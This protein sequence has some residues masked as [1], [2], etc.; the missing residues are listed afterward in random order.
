MERPFKI[1][2]PPQGRTVDS[3]VLIADDDDKTP[4]QASFANRV[5]ASDRQSFT[6]DRTENFFEHESQDFRKSV[7]WFDDR[8][9]AGS[10]SESTRKKTPSTT[11]RKER[12]H[13]F[14]AFRNKCKFA[15]CFLCFIGHWRAFVVIGGGGGSSSS[16]GNPTIQAPE[17]KGGQAT[18]Q[19]QQ[20]QPKSG[21]LLHRI[22][23]KCANFGRENARRVRSSC[24][25]KKCDGLHYSL[26][27]LTSQCV[28]RKKHMRRLQ[29]LMLSAP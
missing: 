29:R 10:Q 5:E 26:D 24:R 27:L 23:K 14:G 20:Q 1:S 28:R 2:L 4:T 12:K 16:T 6:S 15:S 13:R 19:Q 22:L 8:D 7:P 3:A 9:A 21:V 18:M 17:A 11:R 25:Q